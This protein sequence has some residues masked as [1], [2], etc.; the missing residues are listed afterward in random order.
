MDER[1]SYFPGAD[2]GFQVRG[3]TLK[4]IAPSGGVAKIFGVFRGKKSRFY[5]KK[6]IIFFPILGGVCTRSAPAF[7]F[8]SVSS[9]TAIYRHGMCFR[10]SSVLVLSILF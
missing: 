5:A 10:V 9:R 1:E 7:G 6:K 8:S 3:G 2:A 4:K